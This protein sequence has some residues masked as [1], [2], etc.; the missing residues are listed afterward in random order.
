MPRP[1]TAPPGAGLEGVRTDKPRG[2]YSPRLCEACGALLAGR[3][4]SRFCSPK[5][6]AKAQRKRTDERLAIVSRRPSRAARFEV[7]L[8]AEQIAALARYQESIGAES[9]SAAVRALIDSSLCGGRR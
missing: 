2:D 8:A 5:C 3:S 7:Y 6:R 9:R 4:D 1:A